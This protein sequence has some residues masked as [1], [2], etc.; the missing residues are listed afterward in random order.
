MIYFGIWRL[1]DLPTTVTPYYTFLRD[2]KLPLWAL[3][4]G[5]PIPNIFHLYTTNLHVPKIS[6]KYVAYPGF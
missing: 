5:P 3:L 1:W 2:I 4:Q 6:N